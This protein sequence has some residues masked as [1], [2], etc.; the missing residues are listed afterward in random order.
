MLQWKTVDGGFRPSHITLHM[1]PQTLI[2]NDTQQG[3]IVLNYSC[4]L[5]DKSITTAKVVAAIKTLIV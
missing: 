4:D 5:P 2:T 1:H 3:N